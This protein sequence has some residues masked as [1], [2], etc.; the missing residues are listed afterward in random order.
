M[1]GLVTAE[2]REVVP[3]SVE[4]LSPPYSLSAEIDIENANIIAATPPTRQNR[5]WNK[6]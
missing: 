3:A 2:K 1:A 5:T 6:E 4:V